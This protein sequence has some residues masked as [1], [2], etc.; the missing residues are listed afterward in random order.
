MHRQPR[1]DRLRNV[2]AIESHER[3]GR[4]VVANGVDEDDDS[5]SSR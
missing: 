1:R 4:P 2:V 5:A 3:P